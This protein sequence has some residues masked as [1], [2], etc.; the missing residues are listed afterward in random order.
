LDL[1]YN[2]QDTNETTTND[3]N[4]K[5]HHKHHRETWKGKADFFLSALAY[6]VGLGLDYFVQNCS[7]SFT[8]EN[9]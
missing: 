4:T 2:R 1:E 8:Y 9:V 6:A 7:K 3:A 5:T